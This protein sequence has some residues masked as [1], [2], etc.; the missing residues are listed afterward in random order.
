MVGGFPELDAWAAQSWR[1]G[2][3]RAYAQKLAK[4][5]EFYKASGETSLARVL[6]GFLAA[7]AEA[8]ERQST[9]RGYNAALRAAQDLGWIGPTVQQPHK[10]VAQAASKVGV[11][12][13]LPPE[14]LCV[15]VKRA[16]LQPG[17][18]PMACVAVLCW[19]LWLRVGEMF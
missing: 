8:G 14:G 11:Q 18:L 5:A 9:L 10:R 4:I 3:R 2:T 1:A 7:M 6:A 12:P 19:V 16:E 17:A 13:Y 15:L